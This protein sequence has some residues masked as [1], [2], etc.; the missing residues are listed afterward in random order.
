MIEAIDAIARRHSPLAVGTVGLIEVKP[1]SRN[2]VPGEVFF[3]VDFRHPSGAVLD[4]MEKEM[5]GEFEAMLS[6][7]PIT[8]AI[9]RIWDQ[10]PVAFDPACVN[11]VRQAAALS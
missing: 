3:T 2:V 9:T 6:K 1:N 4:A 10:P 7:L 11:S 8:G 5:N